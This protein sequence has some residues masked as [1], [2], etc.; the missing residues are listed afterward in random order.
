MRLEQLHYLL[1]TA[2]CHSMHKASDILH[3]SQ[4]NI[5]K[6]IRDLE[7]ELAVLLFDRTTSGLYL[8]LEGEK[9]Y[10]L[11]SE[12]CTCTDK[13][14]HL[15]QSDVQLSQYQKLKGDFTVVSI[16]GYSL[17]VYNA[18]QQF[19]QTSPRVH[20]HLEERESLDTI[21]Y[22]LQKDSEWGLT[23]MDSELALLTVPPDF[24][25]TYEVLLLRRDYLKV[26]TT[27]SSPLVQYQSVSDKQ[28][29]AYPLVAYKTSAAQPPLVQLLLERE[30]LKPDW[31]LMS[32]SHTVFNEA[33]LKK[34][35]VSLSSD[36]IIKSATRTN[37]AS[38][39]LLPMSRKIP[40]VHIIVKKKT[41]S[42]AGQ[43]F[44]SYML[45]TLAQFG[46]EPTLYFPED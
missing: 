33:L 31:L 34:S 40:L 1:V 23:T 17:F 28:L 2:N 27:V 26:L 22:L 10:L 13:I 38:L 19:H 6:A 12:V 15:F 9:V 45:N 24:W 8:T 29:C 37:N 11:A 44:H 39:L 36:L 7:K 35:A 3:V 30:G 41:L 25:Q 43:L 21:T 4:Q 42:D 46:L 16:P 18:F 14:R 5:S 20:F 32:N